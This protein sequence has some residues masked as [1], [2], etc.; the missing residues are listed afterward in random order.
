MITIVAMVAGMAL[1]VTRARPR[2][3]AVGRQ[4]PARDRAFAP[5]RMRAPERPPPALAWLWQKGFAEK[6]IAGQVVHAGR[7]VAGAVVRLTTEELRIGEWVLADVETDDAG[8]FDFGAR[9][10][11][12]YRVVAQARGLVAGG[13]LLDLRARDP[14]PAPG[15]VTV[16]LRDCELHISGTVRDAAGGIIAGARVRAATR[17]EV[18]GGVL[19]D[20]Q[21]RYEVCL[22]AGPA[23]IE[24]AADGYG[25]GL[26]HTRGR[27][28]ARVD[29]AL[30]PEV[31]IAGRVVDDAGAPV[32]G[33]VVIAETT[34]HD[35][36]QLTESA[37]DGGFHIEGLIAG[38]Y[39]VV[40]RDGERAGDETVTLAASGATT[41][42]TL[43]LERRATLPGRVLVGRRPAGDAT[44]IARSTDE[45]W[46]LGSAVTQG[47]GRFAI[48][49][50]P[51]GQVKIVVERHK[52]VSPDPIIDVGEA[53][54]E[55]V[56]ELLADV[57]GRVVLAGKPIPRA[58]VR[59]YR[60]MEHRSSTLTKDDGTFELEGVPPATYEIAATSATEGAA[61]KR[62]PL[63]VGV[64]DVDGLVLDLD[65]TASI[66]GAV[67]DAKGAPVGG[68]MVHFVS[69]GVE[70]G[71]GDGSSDTTA[72]D[73]TFH[74]GGLAAGS[75]QPELQGARAP[76]AQLPPPGGGRHPAVQVADAASRVEGV[77]LTIASSD[78][79]ISGRVVR[80]G[81]PVSGIDIAAAGSGSG[82]EA[83]A[84]SGADGTF[85]LERLRPGRYELRPLRDMQPSVSAEAGARDVVLELPATGRIEGV[86]R[87]FRAPPEVTVDG[88]NGGGGHRRADVAESRFVVADAPVGSYDV[89]A[90]ASNAQHAT[91]RVNVTADQVSRLTL[92]AGGTGTLTGA[93]V[94]VR[95]RAAIP[96]VRC[97]W[98][99][100][101]STSIRPTDTDA[102]GRFSFTVPAGAIRVDCSANRPSVMT[103]RDVS[104]E[105]EPGATSH[106]D[107]EM[108]AMRTGRPT[109]A[110]GVEL[111]EVGYRMTTMSSE[112]GAVPTEV[113]TS[114]PH[115]ILS[116]RGA[117]A[118][119]GLRVGDDLVAV[120]GLPIAGMQTHVVYALMND[121]SVGEP[122]KLTVDREGAELTFDV[123]MDATPAPPRDE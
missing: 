23:H 19:S 107:V 92:T 109:G 10:P 4:D 41:E 63:E 44:V 118:S 102:T 14:R 32:G 5:A 59:L 90:I 73:G 89:T 114:G 87:G 47:D 30:S 98:Q 122:V 39:R 55:L 56:C 45:K 67:V 88:L 113:V 28:A 43:T 7:P 78:L 95:T 117:A 79:T 31:A 119:S 49:G 21:G 105:V 96:G 36:G 99:I 84:Q 40:A 82:D 54:V 91:G 76:W 22:L 37:D 80:R 97:Y 69:E 48:A 68:V 46:V 2:E 12:Q 15:D 38:T 26:E 66:A 1:W 123:A 42:L 35:P 85:L 58:E 8:R 72:A 120:D 16:E 81:E 121:R 18:F 60:D 74:V 71:W 106:V 25:T 83:V 53:A 9:P 64:Q 75:Y 101:G 111:D 51:R 93:V 3:D 65:L 116:L 34:G 17:S 6:R 100:R 86:L 62:R 27:S 104:V 13:V 103:V 52:I 11:T 61:M 50:L 110:V 108:V 94:D 57:S 70:G 33:A 77:R 24:A 20:E 112:P 29:F 115:R